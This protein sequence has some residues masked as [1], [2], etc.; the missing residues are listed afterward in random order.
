MSG[1]RHAVLVGNGNFPGDNPGSDPVLPS[2][3]CS[4]ADVAGLKEVLEAADH[5]GYRVTAL[6]DRPH[7][8][9]RRVIHD[10]L[11]KAS[12]DD[13]VLIYYSGHGKLDEGGNLYLAGSDTDPEALDPTA[14]AAADIQKYVAES[15]AAARIVILD[16]CFS[17]AVGQAFLRGA[18][19]GEVADQA[20][21][22]VRQLEGRGVFYLTASTDT[23]TAEE[24]DQDRYSLL[25]K[26]I[27]DG[28]QGG[29]ADGD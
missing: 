23:Q 16:C 25:T 17:G 15:R 20:G 19:K 21:Q 3:R 7:G 11:R 28:I 5:G 24:K 26:H 18:A 10:C 14:L 8:Q 22:A 6:I 12:P 9:A 27:I 13:Q 2:L 4:A 29:Q 1:I